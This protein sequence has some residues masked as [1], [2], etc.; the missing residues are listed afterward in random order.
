[1]KLLLLDLPGL[2]CAAILGG[3][4]IYF[5]GP[6]GLQYLALMLVF[7]VAGVVVTKYDYERKRELAVFEHERSWEN[8]VAN[9]FVPT[10]LI[11]LGAFHPGMLGA[12]IGSIAAITADKFA[13]E[14]GVLGGNPFMLPFF[15]PVRP[16]VSGAVSLL[17][18]FVSFDGAALI[19]VAA[20]FLFPGQYSF[21]D[22]LL[23]ASVGFVGSFVDTIAGIPETMGF[24]NKSTT[25][26]ICAISGAVLGYFLLH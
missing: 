20:F 23:I 15:K 16:G 6:L 11:V 18:F 25:N 26:I 12:Y 21:I 8:V 14:L 3:S 1:M 22:V 10:L 7:L 5:G 4:I 24:G 13:S 17:G 19:G 9:G 2:I